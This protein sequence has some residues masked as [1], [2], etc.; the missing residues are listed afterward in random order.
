MHYICLICQGFPGLKGIIS[1][2]RKKTTICF[3]CSELDER[4]Q[5]YP[6]SCL[7]NTML[8][9]TFVGLA[10]RLPGV[11]S[12]WGLMW[13][14]QEVTAHGQEIVYNKHD[15]LIADPLSDENAS[16]PLPL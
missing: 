6:C 8:Q 5:S 7:P 12:H 4:G 10:E 11:L 1:Y 16:P 3:F 14:P 15:V 13:R 9:L 2:F